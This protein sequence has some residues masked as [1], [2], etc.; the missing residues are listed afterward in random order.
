MRT[1]L[2]LL[3]ASFTVSASAQEQKPAAAAAA[4]PKITYDDDVKPILR[5]HCFTCHNQGQAKSG[6]VLDSFPKLMEGGSSG[7]VVFAGDLENSRLWALVSHT[8]QPSMPPMQDKL[9]E[10]KLAVIKK[11]IEAGALENKGAQA[12]I[13]KKSSLAMAAPAGATKP[14][15]PA[16]M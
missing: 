16:A 9:P 15:G 12:V 7:Q 6:L 5:E 8:E 4:P 14:T 2:L 13:K 1:I 10:A 11:W 3:L